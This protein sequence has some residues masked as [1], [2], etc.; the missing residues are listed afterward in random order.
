MKNVYGDA[1]SNANGKTEGIEAVSPE[2]DN[3]IDACNS[4]Q[5]GCVADRARNAR[6]S[7][8]ALFV[9]PRRK[10]PEP[11]SM[12]RGFSISGSQPLLMSKR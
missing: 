10:V 12:L 2:L 8:P 3:W 11:A 6:S 9:P 7:L 1:N 4:K 5:F